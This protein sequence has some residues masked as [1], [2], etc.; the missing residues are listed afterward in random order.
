MINESRNKTIYHPSN[1]SISKINPKKR[2][3]SIEAYLKNPQSKLKTN[4]PRS[5]KA[6]IKLG[7]T[8]EI[9]IYKTF[10]ECCKEIK[11]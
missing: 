5:L 1:P 4:S 7:Y 9:L 6:I 11:I 2:I 8:Q 10:K 3:V